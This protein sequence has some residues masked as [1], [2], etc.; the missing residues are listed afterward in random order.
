MSESASHANDEGL[1]RLDLSLIQNR[2]TGKVFA[3]GS[4]CE[5]R[6]DISGAAIEGVVAEL[7]VD[8]LRR[9]CQ[10]VPDAELD[11]LTRL[12]LAGGGA[13]GIAVL[14]SDDHPSKPL[15]PWQ[16]FYELEMDAAQTYICRFLGGMLFRPVRGF[17][18]LEPDDDVVVIGSQVSN[19]AARVLLGTANQQTPPFSVEQETWRTELHWNLCTP[20]DAPLTEVQEFKGKRTSS[21]HVL[22]ERDGSRSY[23]AR[24][25]P[26]GMRYLDDYLLVTSLPRGKRGNRRALIFSGLHGA[27]TRAVDLILREPPIGLLAEAAHRIAGASDF[28][29]L[30]HVDTAPDG[31]G[32]SL[33]KSID[34]VDARALVV[35]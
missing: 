24:R 23:A 19:L 18:Q 32:E 11:L 22:C 7:F 20:A 14:P 31:R 4:L 15:R 34:L 33:P 26:A 1:D 35:A 28:Q 3:R 16:P 10:V 30:L 29:M 27:G 8:D 25:G 13:N 12:F 17:P 9:R 6:I 5:S 21:G 2:L